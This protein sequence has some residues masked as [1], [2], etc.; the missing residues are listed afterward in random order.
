M[1]DY[2]LIVL[3]GG[4]AG[5]TS[6]I[7]AAKAGMN[8][9]IFEREHLGGTCLNRG[10]I[11][12]KTLLHSAELFASASAW[13]EMGVLAENVRLD[14]PAIYARKNSIVEK[15]RAGLGS[16]MKLN[17]IDVFSEEAVFVADNTVIAGG[18]TYT[19]QR[20]LIATG[21]S[22]A[23][24][25][26]PG[27]ELTVNSDRVLAEPLAGKSVAIIGGGVIGVEFASY[28]AD[29]GRAVTVIEMEDRVLPMM[30]KDL[31][32]Q[33]AAVLKKKGIVL[34][35]AAAVERFEKAEQGVAAHIR[36]KG[37]PE[38]VAADAVVVSVGR[39][40]NTTGL[41]LE[42]IGVKT[43]RGVA[44]D[45]RMHTGVAEIYAAGDV[46]ARVQL[47]HYAAASATVAVEA[48]LGL[49]PSMD[50]NTV[51]AC[52][53]TSP[54]IATVGLTEA[55]C[56][57]RGLEVEVGKYPMGGNGKSMI[58]GVDRG[59]I[60]TI[61]EKSTG[62]VLGA[63]AFCCRGTDILG[64]LVLAVSQNIPREQLLRVIHAHPTTMEGVFE[65]LEASEGRGIY[66]R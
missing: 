33:L 14:E 30:E 35:T 8:V 54:E 43:Q 51:P 20:F 16:L 5:Y 10:C 28:F 11:P 40:A 66:Q 50:L 57:A 42:K 4:V 44:V 52:V 63:T 53:Y 38:V 25:G 56:A 41:G 61:V 29:T 19:A 36:V 65:S 22:P 62:R 21:S 7:R 17:K 47:A 23:M 6:A 31:S 37:Q 27:I 15:L 2:S 26:I 48:M 18:K 59:F 58:E 32:A 64:E 12:T 24:L 55:E 13:A 45:D 1:S 3:G 34:K 46:T 39:R 9:A 60:K 49:P